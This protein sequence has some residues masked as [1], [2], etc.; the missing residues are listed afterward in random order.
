MV[1]KNIFIAGLLSI[2]SIGLFSA[3]KVINKQN[4]VVENHAVSA[5][6]SGNYY[7]SISSS[8]TGSDLLGALRKLNSSKKKSSVGYD[9]FKSFAAKCDVNPDGGNKIVGFYDNT[10]LGPAWDSAKT[11]NRE[12]MWPKSRKGSLVENDAHMVRPASVAINSE[13]GNKFFGIGNGT[14]DPGQY[15]TD[16]RGISA[17]IIFYCAV[18]DSALSLVDLNDDQADNGTMGKLSTLLKW[19]LD[20]LP[21]TSSLELR[22]EQ[23]R[24]NVIETDSKGQ[25][26]RNPFIDHP[27]YACKIWGNTNDATKAICQGHM[28]DKDDPS[29]R[30]VG[31]FTKTTYEVGDKLD[32]TGVNI[33]YNAG[34]DD[35]ID[36]DVTDAVTWEPDT[37][38]G[39][40]K[41]EILAKY[42]DLV[43]SCGQVTVNGEEIVT[44]PKV[45]TKYR[46]G[47]DNTQ[48]NKL[49]FV[50]GN[51][52]TSYSGS[53]ITDK[54][55]AADVEV[56]NATGGYYL[57]VTKQGGSATY[58]ESYV[59]GAY[60]DLRFS[61]SPITVWTFNT[62]YN[63]FTTEISGCTN[64]KKNGTNFIGT[65][66]TYEDLRISSYSYI[67]SETNYPAHLYEVDSGE[68]EESLAIYGELDKDEYYVG[69]TFDPTG[70]S[71]EY[72]LNGATTDVTDD[73]TWNLGL[74][75]TEGNFVLTATYK[76]L[77]ANYAGLVIVTEYIPDE[78]LIIS[79]TLKT[80]TYKV[81]DWIDPTGVTVSYRLEDSFID[82][83]NKVTWDPMQFEYEGEVLVNIYYSSIYSDLMVCYGYVTVVGDSYSS[84][85]QS[86][87][88]ESKSEDISSEAESSYSEEISSEET[89]FESTSSE[90][91]SSEVT[92]SE[93]VSSS[94]ETSSLDSSSSGGDT[95]SKKGGGCSA[96]IGGSSSIVFILGFTALFFAIR[97][98]VRSKKE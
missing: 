39:S 23:N 82:V 98:L 65:F 32:P 3:G 17:R 8:L 68:D 42:N 29:L 69:E 47:F 35:G 57:K 4:E 6:Y 22:T 90:K 21:G 31:N 84:E 55:K 88:E 77:T 15:H 97:Q 51:M 67:T 7:D 30:A 62:Q 66:G 87:E 9:G 86:S 44:S 25:G 92:S 46:L 48:V 76:G 60:V 33:I 24:N 53:T 27:E 59:D 34:G 36:V 45:G 49:L 40:G 26:N 28:D 12:H 91:Q 95:P 63:T 83:T 18:A 16:Y 79:G 14:Y 71:V 41:I 38:T 89:S 58:L 96:S 5:T 37:F 43:C 1:K 2:L 50:D 64:T 78:E 73:V 85:E 13:R 75:D 10:L 52:A 94:T 20:Y 11:W 56:E 93:Q 74:L 70:L 54:D 81:G 72:T 80:T 19:N 61:S